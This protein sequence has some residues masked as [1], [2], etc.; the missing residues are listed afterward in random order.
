MDDNKR[1]TEQE[2]SVSGNRLSAHAQLQKW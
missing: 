1:L 2:Q